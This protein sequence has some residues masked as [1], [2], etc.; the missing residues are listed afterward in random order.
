MPTAIDVRA[1]ENAEY[2]NTV[3]DK[4]ADIIEEMAA[5]KQGWTA[6][7][8]LEQA[9]REFRNQNGHGE[10]QFNLTA[11]INSL[12][13]DQSNQP[14]SL[15]E[16]PAPGYSAE[17]AATTLREAAPATGNT[18]ADVSAGLSLMPLIH[19]IRTRHSRSFL[20]MG[21][22]SSSWA[23]VTG[24]GRAGTTQTRSPSGV[25]I[26]NATTT[27]SWIG[28]LRA[29]APLPLVPNSCST[30]AK[31]ACPVFPIPHKRVSHPG[32]GRPHVPTGR[33]SGPW[34]P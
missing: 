1:N 18:P 27:L 34:G 7:T 33:F 11:L 13:E 12:N 25:N 32:P 31:P 24:Q 17:T 19:S 16:S 22:T 15:L 5:G 10:I 2:T 21:P 6:V 9:D 8:A 14:K 4:A 26:Q 3:I 23:A 30:L 29:V 20:V 28:P